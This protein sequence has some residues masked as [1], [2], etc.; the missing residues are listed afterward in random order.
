[1]DIQ[2][3]AQDEIVDVS[4]MQNYDDES[5]EI[6]PMTPCQQY[7]FMV[8][9]ETCSYPNVIYTSDEW[10]LLVERLLDEVSIKKLTGNEREYRISRVRHCQ[11]YINEAR[12]VLGK[13]SVQYIY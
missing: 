10:D 6:L 7:E 12:T 4:P 9:I 2:Y 1:M 3:V 5:T 11:Q 8:N 13:P